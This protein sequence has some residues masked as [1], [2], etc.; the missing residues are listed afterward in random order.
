MLRPQRGAI[1][2]A[3]FVLM[4]Q[5]AALLAGPA[6]RRARHRR[7]ACRAR[8]PTTPARSNLAVVV[9]LVIA[10]AGFVLGRL[11]IVLVARIGEGFLRMTCATGCSGT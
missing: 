7:T 6:A 8:S 3:A 9:Y 10:F 4:A 2:V 1:I 5:A 11:A